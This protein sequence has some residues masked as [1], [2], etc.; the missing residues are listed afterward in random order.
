MG[1]ACV[2]VDSAGNIIVVDQNN[3]RVRRITA[4][5]AVSTIAGSGEEGF[6]DGVGAAA[7]FDWPFGVAVDSEGNIIVADRCNSSVRLLPLAAAPCLAWPECHE[8]MTTMGSPYF[9]NQLELLHTGKLSDVCFKVNT[10]FGLILICT[11]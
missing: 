4:A 1:L 6:A 10:L 11:Q 8:V 3:N 7:Q 2:A 5:G 9:T